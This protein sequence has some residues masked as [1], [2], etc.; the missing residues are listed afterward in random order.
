MQTGFNKV[1][2]WLNVNKL[3][4]NIKKTK[5][6]LFRSSNKKPKHETKLSINDGDIKQVKNTILLGIITD[7][8]LTWSEHIAQVV[9]KISRASG[10]IVKIRHFLSRNAM[11]LI[12]YALVYP[13]LIYGNLIG[14]TPTSLEFKNY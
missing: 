6:V 5:F 8:C 2:N 10:I 11:K 1:N 9:K 12:Y 13:Y 4:L 14:A 3:S 7:E